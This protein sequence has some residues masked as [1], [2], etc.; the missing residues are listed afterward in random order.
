M[1]LKRAFADYV[2]HLATALGHADRRGPLEDYCRGL[3][4]PGE[5]KSIEP[6]AARVA[7]RQVSAT[8][9]SLHHFVAQS[10]WE[11]AAVLGAV[12]AYV[13]PRLT[14][15]RPI[16]AWIVDDTGFPKKGTHSVGVAR[17]YCGER[18]KQDNCQV[19]VSLS[20][21]N[22]AASLPVAYQ[23]YLPKEWAQDRERR[24]RAG[25][26]QELEFRT[27]PAIAL[28]Q[29]RA[30]QAAGVP[31]GVVLADA[32]YGQDSGF[33]GELSALALSYV[34]GI[35]KPTTVWAPGT[36]PLPA[37]PWSGR[38]RRPR[39][40]RRDA[41][42]QPLAVEALARALPTS[43]WQTVS[44]R[45]GTNTEL[46]SRFAAVRVRP[47]HRDHLKS[48][49]A[50]EEWLLIEWPAEDE[51]PFKYWLSTLPAETVLAELVRLAKLR[52]RIE[53]D[54][55]ELKQELGLGHFEGRGWRGFHHHATL[56]IAA[57]GFLAAHRTAFSPGALRR[58]LLG[59]APAVPAGFRPRGAT[60]AGRAPCARLDRHGA[61]AAGARVAQASTR[62]SL[63]PAG[64]AL[65][66]RAPWHVMTQ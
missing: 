58:T 60:G 17:Q 34:V 63:L 64:R 26:P 44:W 54:Y 27:K 65:S 45:E 8:H 40:L 5:R 43:A 11:D 41:E 13:L 51:E 14:A 10:A 16:E 4:L 50:P 62:V 32:G 12:R 66:G 38:G 56:C 9:Q 42:H 61:S 33:R 28:A 59:E 19:A 29:I 30:A 1:N 3:L 35:Q 23:L 22:E 21:A 20:V 7:P 46:A 36:G 39:R 48:E 31:A 18:G 2:E 24:A 25:V 47:A 57:Y 55:Q 53:R 15:E 52:W 37:K 49:P 6:M